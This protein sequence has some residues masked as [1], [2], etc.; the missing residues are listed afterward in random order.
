MQ[1]YDKIYGTYR[2]SGI[3]EKLIQ[4]SPFQR[5]KR[6]HQGGAIFLIKPE[7][8]HTRYEHSIGVMHLIQ[9]LG[10]EEKE[11]VAGLLHDLSHTAFSHLVDYVLDNEK[12][13]YHE[14]VF[15][16]VL[17]SSEIKAILKQYGYN[18][19][20][21]FHMK[22]FKLLAHPL[23]G[24][25]ADRIDYTLRDLYQIGMLRLNEI[26]WFLGGLIVVE[27][28]TICK[29]IEYATWFQKKYQILIQDY[30]NS[31]A[32]N[33][34]N[35][36]MK[37]LLQDCLKKKVITMADFEEDDFFLMNKIETTMHK[38]IHNLLPS[39]TEGKNAVTQKS[40]IVD[41]EVVL[42]GKLIKVSDLTN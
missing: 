16:K 2:L 20:D 13:D 22:S 37:I 33:K 42:N 39:F 36:Q 3:F 28:R 30:F 12:E 11:Q 4:S 21:F 41:P 34:I 31:P 24:L 40:R 23:P 6:I 26:D 1:Y 17:T 35:N 8:N 38:R 18:S 15:E 25:S 7:I 14:Q 19:Q 32:A 9:R 29:G 10:G 5:L 27:G